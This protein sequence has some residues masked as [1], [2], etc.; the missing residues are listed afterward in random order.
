[1]N[2]FHMYII[3]IVLVIILFIYGYIRIKYGF[4][5]YQPVFH[6]YDFWY[7]LFPCGIIQH[8][9]PEKN[10]F[11]NID[12]IEFLSL[13]NADES[14]MDKVVHFIQTNYLQNTDNKFHPEK[15]NIIKYFAGHGESIH[16]CF[17]SLCW[18]EEFLQDID[19]SGELVKNK[20]LV[21]I[22]TTRPLYIKFKKDK[23]QLVA[24]YVDYLCVHKDYR[25]KGYAPQ[26]IQT[27]HYHQRN[28]NPGVH[29]SLFKR[30][31]KLTG[32]VPLCV[33][34]TYGFSMK[35]WK[36][37]LDIPST[38]KI[39]EC[40]SQNIRYLLEFMRETADLFDITM[41]TEIANILELINSRNMYIYFVLDIA[42]DK[43]MSA[44]FFRNSCVTIQKDCKIISCFAS[45]CRENYIDDAF[46]YGFKCAL[47]MIPMMDYL[48]LA[49]EDISHNK[50]IIDNLQIKNKV[51][52]VSPTAYFFYNFAYH[53]FSSDKVFFVS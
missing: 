39:L 41:T 38:D 3:I 13:A 9:L 12:A 42:S 46:V 19:S 6:A 33:Y 35:G 27:H 53:P 45:I 25:K 47:F 37:P 29:V 32:I 15:H 51:D 11:T 31:N 50:K 22:M 23:S 24:Y 36:K 1:M 17:L 44:Y 20:K 30:E 5:Y 28:K 10:R 52:V 34:S 7:Y 21:G 26:I 4:W 2:E 16:P 49:V 8:E 40:S 14:T 48:F 43:V 18:E